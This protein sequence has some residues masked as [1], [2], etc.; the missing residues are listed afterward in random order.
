MSIGRAKRTVMISLDQLPAR[1]PAIMSALE[2][3]VALLR[4]AFSFGL[5]GLV[6][7]FV[8]FGVFMLGVKL[9]P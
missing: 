2:A 7:T 4:K 9:T 5:I 1:F 8:D 6:N 3:R